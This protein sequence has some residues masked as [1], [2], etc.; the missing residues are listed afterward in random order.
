ML[1]VTTGRTPGATSGGTLIT[2]KNHATGSVE[3]S[4][5]ASIQLSTV[6]EWVAFEFSWAVT[7]YETSQALALPA[8]DDIEWHDGGID[9]AQV[10]PTSGHSGSSTLTTST[11]IGNAAYRVYVRATSTRAL[12]DLVETVSNIVYGYGVPK[13]LAPS[14]S[15]PSITSIANTSGTF[16]F[17]ATDPNGDSVTVKYQI[18]EHDL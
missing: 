15:G 14:I 4:G 16:T 5:L 11:V 13:N 8:I 12:G 3:T 7:N 18:V 10:A 9:P 17:T 6:N 1:K 2:T